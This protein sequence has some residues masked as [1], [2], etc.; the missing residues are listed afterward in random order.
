LSPCV[1]MFRVTK[2][3][4]SSAD[5]VAVHSVF[6]RPF[7]C[8]AAS[9]KLVTG[10]IELTGPLGFASLPRL[11]LPSRQGAP[12]GAT[13][14]RRAVTG[15]FG[16]GNERNGHMGGSLSQWSLPKGMRNHRAVQTETS[17]RYDV[18]ISSVAGLSI[19]AQKSPRKQATGGMVTS[20]AARYDSLLKRRPTIRTD[21]VRFNQT[22]TR[23][24]TRVDGVAYRAGPFFF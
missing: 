4:G 8:S 5:A 20:L 19:S 6:L 13:P 23:A 1:F 21:G 12:A 22:L 17:P 11:V 15:H 24:R 16:N 14:T 3:P 9:A 2:L 7:S 10:A 18:P